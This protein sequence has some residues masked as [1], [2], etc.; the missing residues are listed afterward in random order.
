MCGHTL[1]QLAAIC[2]SSFHFCCRTRWLQEVEIEVFFSAIE[3]GKL[4]FLVLA[5]LAFQSLS[6]HGFFGTC[7]RHIFGSETWG[8]PPRLHVGSLVQTQP[9]V[10]VERRLGCREISG[11]RRG[12]GT[13]CI[14]PRMIN[15]LSIMMKKAGSQAGGGRRKAGIR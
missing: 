2:N 1:L 13:K 6:L 15:Y 3:T 8:M 11:S 7:C 9:V 4:G 14:L 10:D 12:S 5:L